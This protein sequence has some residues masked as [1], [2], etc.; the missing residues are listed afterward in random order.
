MVRSPEGK[1]LP[2]IFGKL[3]GRGVHLCPD[4]KC[5]QRAFQQNSFS[6]TLRAPV[7]VDNIEDISIRLA[8]T[9]IESI[10]SQIRSLIS[11]CVRSGW[12]IGGRTVVL[13]AINSKKIAAIF[14]A[15]DAAD[16][17]Q[18]EFRRHAES[19]NIP[20]YEIFTK[21]QLS[22]FHNGK[23]LAVFGIQHRGLAD[24]ICNETIKLHSLQESLDNSNNQLK[25][26]LNKPVANC[27]KNKFSMASSNGRY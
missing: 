5:I 7:L 14:V 19:T 8:N 26:N 3:E 25:T 17:L 21:S 23:P 16:S 20:I 6:K 12:L 9:F 18:Q 1:L 4:L 22:K 11:I 27:V 2:D 10:S 15:R 13:E 24:N